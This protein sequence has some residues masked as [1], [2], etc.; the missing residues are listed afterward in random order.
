MILSEVNCELTLAFSNPLI[1]AIFIHLIA[2]FPFFCYLMQL[3]MSTRAIVSCI[4]SPSPTIA[5]IVRATVE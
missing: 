2:I 5:A 1:T 4:K 3:I